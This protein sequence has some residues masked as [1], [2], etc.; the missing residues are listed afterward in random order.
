M[1][2]PQPSEATIDEPL[3]PVEGDCPECGQAT[4]F[5][6]RLVDYRGWLR[7]TKCRSCLTTLN[8]ERIDPPAQAT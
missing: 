4:L 5:S 8:S 7:V 6:Y 2:F 3:D 1:L